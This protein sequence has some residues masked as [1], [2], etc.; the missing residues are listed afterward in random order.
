MKWALEGSWMKPKTN[1]ASNFFARLSP[2]ANGEILLGRL[3]LDS[4]V[5]GREALRRPRPPL[6][7]YLSYSCILLVNHGVRPYPLCPPKS[8]SVRLLG[9]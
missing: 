9:I 2:R 3:T 7:P 6:K 5:P 8:K 1:I 4:V